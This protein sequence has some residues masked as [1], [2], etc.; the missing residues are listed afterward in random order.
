MTYKELRDKLN[1]LT[2]EQLDCDLTIVDL[3]LEET[4]PICDFVS[5]WSSRERDALG[6]DIVDGVLDDEH[7]Y[8]TYC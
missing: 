1:T 4:Y 5:D 7:L 6:L 2:D 3:D 8:F